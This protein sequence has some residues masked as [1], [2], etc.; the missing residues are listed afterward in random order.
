MEAAAGRQS[1]NQTCKHSSCSRAIQMEAE[2]SRGGALLYWELWSPAVSRH[3]Q[4][5]THTHTQT[6]PRPSQWFAPMTRCDCVES[7]SVARSKPIISLFWQRLL[8]LLPVQ[9][10]GL[11]SEKQLRLSCL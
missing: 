11:Q 7:L 6:K 1:R 10:E 3:T 9:A 2:R 8:T 5:H 4:T